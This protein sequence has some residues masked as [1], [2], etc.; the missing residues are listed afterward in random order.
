MPLFSPDI[1]GTG[2]PMGRDRG[3]GV[4][5]SVRLPCERGA[6]AKGLGTVRGAACACACACACTCARASAGAA[7]SSAGGGGCVGEGACDAALGLG[8]IAGSASLRKRAVALKARHWHKM[9]DAVAVEA[10][11]DIRDKEGVHSA[12]T[13]ATFL[14]K[15]GTIRIR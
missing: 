4:N 7:S 9:Q 5:S 13:V 1:G 3:V 15:R 8:G 12:P 10:T 2:M 14:L 6:S 11:G